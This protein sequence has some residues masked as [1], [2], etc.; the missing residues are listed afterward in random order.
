[1]SGYP[2]LVL[3]YTLHANNTLAINFTIIIEI[4]ATILLQSTQRNSDHHKEARILISRSRGPTRLRHG[5]AETQAMKARHENTPTGSL[6][7][8]GALQIGAEEQ[9]DVKHASKKHLRITQGITK[10]R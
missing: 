5:V 6:I 8:R 2:H 10:L 7:G 9:E 3:R 4:S 1:M